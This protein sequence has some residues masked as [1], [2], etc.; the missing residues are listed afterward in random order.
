MCQE[1]GHTL[2]LNHQDEDFTNASVRR[3]GLARAEWGQLDEGDER[4]GSMARYR[5]HLPDGTEAFSFVIWE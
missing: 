4:S 1:V 2:G 3:N 5:R